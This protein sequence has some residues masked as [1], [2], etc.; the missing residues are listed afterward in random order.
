M[1]ITDLLP[2]KREKATDIQR[3]QTQDPIELLRHDMNRWFDEVFDQG[4]GISSLWPEESW[5]GF[6]P[7]VDVVEGDREITV[8]ADLPGLDEQDIELQIESNRLIISGEREQHQEQKRRNVYRT[9]RSYGSFQ[10]SVLLPAEVDADKANAVYKNG[11]LT[12]ELPKVAPTQRKKI[13]VKHS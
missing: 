5:S 9:E 8:T 3:R 10:R 1:S 2:W 12:V 11:V 13:T 4:F 7:S 6:V